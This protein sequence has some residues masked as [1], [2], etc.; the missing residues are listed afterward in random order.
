MAGRSG[1]LGGMEGQ[2][3]VRCHEIEALVFRFSY[4]VRLVLLVAFLFDHDELN[5]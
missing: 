5:H 2:G 4:R 1:V 3:K